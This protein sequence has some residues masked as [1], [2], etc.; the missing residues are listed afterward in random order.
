MLSGGAAALQAA[1]NDESQFSVTRAQEIV[2]RFE[3]GQAESP[4]PAD[5]DRRSRD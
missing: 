4:A 1:E 5:C 3:S 2:Q